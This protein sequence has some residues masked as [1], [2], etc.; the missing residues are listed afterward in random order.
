MNAALASIH[1]YPIKGCAGL[2]PDAWPV[3]GFGLMHDRRWMIVDAAG[4]FVTQRDHPRLALIQ[5]AFDEDA[6]RVDAPGLPTLRVPLRVA[7]DARRDVRVWNDRCAAL[8]TGDEAAEWFA[9]F[10]GFDARLAFMPE[11]TVRQVDP[12]YAADGERVGFAD[13]F[14][15]LLIGAASLD[16]LN[17]RLERPLPMNR[18]RPNLTVLGAAPHAEDAWQRIRIG[19]IAFR[20]VKPCARCVVTTVDQTTAVA[21]SEPLRTLATYRKQNG[22]VMFGQNLIHEGTGI[23]RRGAQV[24]VESRRAV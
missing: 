24:V 20:V 13:A 4:E 3:D 10:L 6:L 5:P 14:P 9:R 12:R 2:S 17:Q 15:F 8:D 16:Q 18:F 11:E 21:G 7:S 19:G 1:V 22:K 23:L